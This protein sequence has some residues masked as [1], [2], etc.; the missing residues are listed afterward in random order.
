MPK[1]TQLVSERALLV[2]TE[3]NSTPEVTG[4]ADVLFVL[5]HILRVARS[6]GVRLGVCKDLLAFQ[7]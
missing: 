4:T 2:T 7:L 5:D 3:T 1:V 6:E